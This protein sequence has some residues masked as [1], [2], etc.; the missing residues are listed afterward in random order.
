MSSNSNIPT[1]AWFQGAP[2]SKLL[3]IL[4]I[5]GHVVFPS[6]NNQLPI[7]FPSTGELIMGMIFL[8]QHL[9]KLEREMSSRQVIVWLAWIWTFAMGVQWMANQTIEQ[10]SK[11]LGPYLWMGGILY[12]YMQY[13]PRLHPKFVSILGIQMSEK[14]LQYIWGFYLLGCQGTVSLLQGLVGGIGAAIYFLAVPNYIPLSIPDSIVHRFPWEIVGGLLFLDP[15]SPIYV[16]LMMTNHPPLG[17]ATA[18]PRPRRTGMHRPTTVPIPV[19]V[20]QVPA[21]SQ[22]AIDQLTAMGFEE[23]RVRQALQHSGNNIERAAD[24]LLSG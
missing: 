4:W 14:A 16:P 13:I 17:R 21:P 18:D 5:V 24:R 22:E 15:P 23:E 10:E 6:H 1:A 20:V 8:A 9:R 7:L 19:P 2:I 11:L 3:C 12:W